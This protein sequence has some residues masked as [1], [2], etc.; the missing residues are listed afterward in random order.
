MTSHHTHP[1]PLID[2]LTQYVAVAF[3]LLALVLLI[4]QGALAFNGQP[5]IL[6]FF[7][8]VTLV[9]LVAPALW[10]TAATPPVAT[11]PDGLRLQPRLWRARNVTWREIAAVKQYP[12]LPDRQGEG[13]RR[14][15]EGRKN[16]H[17]AEGVMLLIPSLSWQYRFTGFFA[18]EG[19]TPVI[20]F[21]NRTHTDYATLI[22]H[23]R[24]HTT[25]VW[26]E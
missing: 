10:L 26:H 24:A 5:P 16:Y 12:L 7:T 21:T 2:L 4:V 23:L 18:G 3:L 9:V 15:L 17:A 8:S 20:A 22:V 1:R 6:L 13:V 14:A 25:E 19:F 11:L